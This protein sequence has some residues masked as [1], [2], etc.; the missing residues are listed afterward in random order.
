MFNLHF[1][2][3]LASTRRIYD[4]KLH[5]FGP[6]LLLLYLFVI[7]FIFLI[8]IGHSEQVPKILGLY[9]SFKVFTDQETIILFIKK[10]HKNNIYKIGQQW[11]LINIETTKV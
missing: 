9:C 11:L 4:K 10:E 6:N 7:F 1:F 2:Q 5:Y 8:K 3:F